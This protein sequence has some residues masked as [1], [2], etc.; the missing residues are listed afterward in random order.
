MLV[1]KF[2]LIDLGLDVG[3]PFRLRRPAIWILLS[4]WL[5]VADDGAILQPTGPVNMT[6]SRLM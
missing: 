6:R 3:P 5:I 2:D 4:T 1:G